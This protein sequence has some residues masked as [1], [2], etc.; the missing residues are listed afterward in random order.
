MASHNAPA[1]HTSEEPGR[2]YAIYIHESHFEAKKRKVQKI[3]AV[4]RVAGEGRVVF[5]SSTN[6]VSVFRREKTRRMSCTQYHT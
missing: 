2:D 6:E 3:Q 4:Y 5:S 1:Q